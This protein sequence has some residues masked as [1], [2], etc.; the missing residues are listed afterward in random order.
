MDAVLQSESLFLG[1]AASDGDISGLLCPALE[2]SM[3]DRT[4]TPER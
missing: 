1:P 3:V 4:M 2:S